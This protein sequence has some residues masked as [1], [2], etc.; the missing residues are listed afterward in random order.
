MPP[1]IQDEPLDMDA[2]SSAAPA[3]D[4]ANADAS[5]ADAAATADSSTATGETEAD[6]LSVVRDV[7]AKSEE[8]SG[9]AAS[10][11][12]GEDGEGADET[13]APAPDDENYSDVPFAA[14]PRFQ[15]LVREKNS[16][17]E[18]AGR[19]R[20]VETFLT[21]ANLTADEA[22]DTMTI[23]GLAKTDPVKAWEQIQPWLQTLAVAA[24][25]VLPPDLEQ[26]VTAGTL[27]REAAQQISRANAVANAAQAKAKFDQQRQQTQQQADLGRSLRTT[28]ETWLNNRRIKDP[29]FAT[30]EARLHERI[31]FLQRTEGV[32][33]TLDGVKAQ[34]NKA[35]TAINKEIGSITRAAPANAN[36]AA[37][38]RKPAIRPVT[39][40]TVA[41]S[42]SQA[43]PTSTLEA[44]RRVKQRATA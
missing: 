21:Q 8:Q 12:E 41:A 20:N 19:Y 16:Y 10:P 34:L 4:E 15:Q 27:T 3:L 1:D 17:R 37:P 24:G 11:T 38:A 7:V 32:P 14:H 42:A 31:V 9:T 44:I 23:A 36:A 29:N 6:N 2:D 13:S 35:Y 33:N 26:Q 39:G 22:A 30:K 28:A 25:V 5:Q 18:D 40:G 43:K